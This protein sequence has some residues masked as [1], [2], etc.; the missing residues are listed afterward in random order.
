MNTDDTRSQSP[1]ATTDTGLPG[2]PGTLNVILHGLF[3]IAVNETRIT[4]YVPNMGFEHSYKAGNWLAETALEQGDF[5]L[6]GV[7]PPTEASKQPF[8]LE[9]NIVLRNVHVVDANCCD[10]VYATLH[11]PYPDS[12]RSLSRLSV[13]DD[14]IGGDSK[15]LILPGSGKFSARVQVLTY[16]FDSDSNLRFGTHP[17]QP[18]LDDGFVNLHIFSEPEQVPE[19]DHVRHAFQMSMGLFAGVDLALRK[20]MDLPDLEDQREIAE[21]PDGIHQLEIEGLLMRQQWL[22]VLGRAIKE[23]RDL[24][25]FW[26][27]PTAFYRSG[28]CTG[29]NVGTKK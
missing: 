17:W 2:S 1:A 11:F 15:N 21:I 5:T 19:E 25:G 4:V 16:R 6:K 10:R 29:S 12:T 13:P 27:D 23:H 7:S 24:N 18:V 9:E 22:A 26:Q 8:S 14:G 3:T 28:S 20:P